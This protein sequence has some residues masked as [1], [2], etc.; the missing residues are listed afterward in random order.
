M[1]CNE[2]KLH[3]PGSFWNFDA[4]KRLVSLTE[5][6]SAI[7]FWTS[8]ICFQENKPKILEP[9]VGSSGRP[10]EKSTS[11]FIHST[12][13]LIIQRIPLYTLSPSFPFTVWLDSLSPL[14]LSSLVFA[15][16]KLL[17]WRWSAHSRFPGQS[18]GNKCTWSESIWHD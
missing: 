5:L 17:I 16:D 1:L 3:K 8:V 6:T 18:L 11:S 10:E 2:C 15:Q 14:L 7:F 9:S 4:E 12:L 13:V